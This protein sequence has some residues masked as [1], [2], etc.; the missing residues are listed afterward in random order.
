MK[1]KPNRILSLM[2]AVV[3]TFGATH[4]AIASVAETESKWLT[5]VPFSEVIKLDYRQ[6]T[7]RMS[8][9]DDESQFIEAWASNNRTEVHPRAAGLLLVHGGCW[10][11]DYGVDHVRPLA[12]ALADHGY[13]V[14]AVEYRRTGQDGGGWPGSLTD[15][16]AAMKKVR[17]QYP[18]M[19][20]TGIGHSAGGHLALL[21][22]TDPR[23]KLTAV[24]GL[25]AITDVREYAKGENGCQKA[26]VAFM[27]GT[28]AEQKDAYAAANTRD[29]NVVPPLYL[30]A[31]KADSIVPIEQNRHP[32]SKKFEGAGIGHFDWIHPGSEAYQ[33][34]I[35]T[36]SRLYD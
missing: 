18:D 14:F 10:L 12:S 17:D 5:Q 6:P 11:K 4:S 29:K 30:M 1:R 23:L 13:N 28:E 3:L 34:L 8:Y 35:N 7:S 27:G 32:Q 16:N 20:L 15:V 31:G 33:R 25:A 22:A 19:A 36:L 21:A 9:G 26:A 24:I 2:S